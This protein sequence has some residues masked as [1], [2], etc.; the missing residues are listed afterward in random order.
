M[1]L[2]REEVFVGGV[3]GSH[4][5]TA[6]NQWIDETKRPFSWSA[7]S[8]ANVAD[9]I[10]HHDWDPG[11]RRRVVKTF[12]A[13]DKDEAWAKRPLILIHD[14]M[15][16]ELQATYVIDGWHRFVMYYKIQKNEPMIKFPTW[17]FTPEELARF[18]VDP[19]Q[20]KMVPR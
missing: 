6:I 13:F 16:G 1:M 15:H 17:I 19:K 10:Q 3:T 14:G 9:M 2:Q 8:N 4:H 7:M 12:K 5:V 18:K 20:L 11:W